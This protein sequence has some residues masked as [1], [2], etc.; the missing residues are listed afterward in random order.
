MLLGVEDVRGRKWEGDQIEVEI[1]ESLIAI[2]NFRWSRQG[3][4]GRSQTDR[5]DPGPANA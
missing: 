2:R 4:A 3:E 1:L 5:E